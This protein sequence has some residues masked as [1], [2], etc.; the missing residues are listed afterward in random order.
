MPLAVHPMSSEKLSMRYSVAGQRVL[1]V[2]LLAQCGIVLTGALVRLTGSGLGCPTW[3]ECT[4]GSL[5]PVSHQAEGWH[6]YI[7]F[8]NRMLTFVVTIA[9]LAGLV[10]ALRHKPRRSSIIT[11]SVLVLLGVAAQAVLGGVTVLAGLHPATVAAHFLV[12]VFLIA[13]AYWAYA[14]SQEDSDAAAIPAVRSEIRLLGQLVLGLSLVVV[15]LGT[16]VTGSGPHSGDAKQTVR[17]HLDPRM[18]A[19][20]HADLVILFLG[21]LVALALALRL[22]DAPARAQRQAVALLS[23]SL[24]QGFI[25]YV[26]YFTGVPELLVAAHV[27]GAIVVWVSTLQMYTALHTRPRIG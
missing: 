27:A 14:R 16:L 13:A 19:W 2:S 5:V 24:L 15:F 18:I 1:L 10:V 20:V 23:V 26:Q 6:K 25:G 21:L 17:L 7:E 8:G 11:L 22:T 9:C 4:D 12:S 3:P